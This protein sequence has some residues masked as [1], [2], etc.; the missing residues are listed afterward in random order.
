MVRNGAAGPDM[1]TLQT[2]QQPD[3]E[4]QAKLEAMGL[5]DPNAFAALTALG[6]IPNPMAMLNAMMLAA[7]EKIEKSEAAYRN[8]S[9]GNAE[10]QERL[11]AFAPVREK[12]HGTGFPDAPPQWAPPREPPSREP[13]PREEQPP[14]KSW[15]ETFRDL[16]ND[17][18]DNKP[19]FDMAPPPE[20]DRNR[21]LLGAE[22][23]KLESR[24]S[25]QAK[26]A[27][28][29]AKAAAEQRS[30]D[31]GGGGQER[32]DNEVLVKAA[33][34]ADDE[35]ARTTLSFLLGGKSS[36]VSGN[37]VLASSSPA[38]HLDK[39]HVGKMPPGVT[40]S[41]VRLEASRHGAVT[42]VIL[43]A[44]G[45]AAY[46][47]FATADMAANA[48]HRMNGR[49]PFAGASQPLEVRLT[50]EIPDN[51]RL[52]ATIPAVSHEQIVDPSTLPSYLQPKQKKRDRSRSG[53]RKMRRRSKSKKQRRKSWLSRSRSLSHT[54]SGQ[55][56]PS[57]G[58]SSTV[59]WWMKK[60]QES[61]SSSSSGSRQRAKK[62]KTE[63]KG[64]KKL[65]A[66][67]KQIAIR[68][69]W[70]QFSLNGETYYYDLETMKTTWD[71]PS[72]FDGPPKGPGRAGGGGPLDGRPTGCLL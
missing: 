63:E 35:P 39:V 46:V 48:V 59:K 67:P 20:R 12:P 44:D 66:R 21:Q 72:D 25:Q 1:S 68:S 54:E 50:A 71:R 40:E 65:V 49:T 23:E 18:P 38:C 69:H 56:I 17:G 61:S 6:A 47:S 57:V 43:E 8:K 3:H 34:G 42:S 27:A 58:C 16:Q 9:A 53:Q 7:Q 60:R 31:G 22:M 70:A 15:M 37:N 52:A 5:P 29:Q 28:T 2:I 64:A 24:L 33:F 10:R 51:V 11:G 36:K 30:K 62:R 26:E 41:A 14:G 32:G 45:S 55:Y 19:P 13:F 4:T